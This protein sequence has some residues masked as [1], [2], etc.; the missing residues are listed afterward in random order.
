MRRRVYLALSVSLYVL[1]GGLLGA[2]VGLILV[3]SWLFL[4]TSKD[5]IVGINLVMASITGLV[6][7]VLGTSETTDYIT[8]SA[9]ELALTMAGLM[10]YLSCT[11]PLL[12]AAELYD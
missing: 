10:F 2:I 6:A 11:L 4:P 7:L 12:L 8:A 3:P 5:I 9:K 1:L